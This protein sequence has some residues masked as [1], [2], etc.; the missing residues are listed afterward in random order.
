M[1]T[2]KSSQYWA[3]ITIPLVI[4]IAISGAVIWLKYSPSH[5]IEI[6]I[7]MADEVQGKFYI[8]D[9]ASNSGYTR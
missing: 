3:L 8:A 9:A 7:P 5:P 2:S 4:I 6:S 1:V